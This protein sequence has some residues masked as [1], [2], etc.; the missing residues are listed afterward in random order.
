MRRLLLALDA[1][2]RPQQQIEA[3]AMLAAALG[4]RLEVLLLEDEEL[5][6]AAA[7]PI[8]QEISSASARTRELSTEALEQALRAI[9]RTVESGVRAVAGNGEGRFHVR[10]GPRDVA[11]EE[12]SAGVDLL[13]LPGRRGVLRF[14]MLPTPGV[15]AICDDSPAGLRTLELARRLSQQTGR[16]LSLVLIGL[17]AQA[18]AEDP[19]SK[20]RDFP[21]GASLEQ[22]LQAVDTGPGNV[23]L[24]SRDVATAGGGTGPADQL[25]SLRC[26]VLVVG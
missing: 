3:A 12:A 13:L 16:A 10:R 14:R 8:M 18:E 4:A 6:A 23:L 19:C 7:L 21:A 20:R 11:L 5:H 26:E 24:I 1:Q 2:D 9:S 17:P 25:A 22:L 15:C